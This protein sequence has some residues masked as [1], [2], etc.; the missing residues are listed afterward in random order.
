MGKTLEVLEQIAT[1]R[2]DC[3]IYT[4]SCHSGGNS[5]DIGSVKDYAHIW[6]YE[7]V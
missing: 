7:G 5:T 3:Y 2:N 4:C 1:D 6:V